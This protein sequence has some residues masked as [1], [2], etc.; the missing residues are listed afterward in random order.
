MHGDNGTS[1]QT[2]QL[3]A[4]LFT[5][6]CDS[7]ILVEKIGDT[8]AAELFKEHDRLVLA[9]QQQWNGRLID[10]SDGLFLLFERPV[11]AL[12]FAL[13]YQRGLSS[14]TRSS[15]LRL[16]ARAGLH[17]GEVILWKN[18]ADAV[19]Y[20][21]KPVE[22][23]GLA[24]PVAARLMQLARPGQILISATAETMVRRSIDS[25]DEL[26]HG[27]K[28]TSFGLWRFK[29]IESPM[30][31]FGAAGPGMKAGRCPRPT[32]KASRVLPFWRRP[33][34][35][36]AESALVLTGIAVLWFIT[37]SEPAIAFAERDW[38]VVADVRNMTGQQVL[39][40]GISQA[41]RISLEQSRYVN[42][43]GDLKTRE[44]LRKML[45]PEDEPIDQQLAVQ[46]A[47][48]DG[49]RA[50][51]LPTIRETSGGVRVSVDVVDPAIG[52]TVYTVAADG[53]GL[54][55]VLAST[56][57][58]VNQ[59]RTR[60]GEAMGEV[61]KA[62]APLPD[63]ATAD[64][65][66][67]HAYARAQT[68]YGEARVPESLRL[69]DIAIGLDPGFAMAR[70]GKVRS[71]AALGRRD[72]ARAE[73]DR[74]L[75]LRDRLTTR[76]ALYFDAWRKEMLSS[77]ET[78]ALDAWKTLADLYPDHHG[79]NV[80]FAA[81]EYQLG[82]Y[83]AAE[84]AASR[85]NVSQNGM[86]GATLQ[87]LGRIRLARQDVPSALAALQQSV[88]FTQGLPSRHLGAAL[89][90]SGDRKAA[91]R[92][93]ATLPSDGPAA[94]LEGTA[95][96]LDK[97]EPEA[98]AAAA[99]RAAA[100]C[101]KSTSV[102][103]FLAVVDLTV[104]AAAGEC[105]SPARFD[106]VASPLLA[107]AADPQ[108]SDR[109]QRLYFAASALYAGQRSGMQALSGRQSR[110]MLAV[111]RDVGDPRATQLVKLLLANEQRIAGDALGA[112]AQL[113]GMVD[114]SELF[115]VHSALATAYQSAGDQAAA[116]RETAWM[117]SNRGR[118]YA[119]YAGSA[120]LQ[121]LNVRDSVSDQ[122]TTR[123]RG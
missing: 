106:K 68:A 1:S 22:V 45:L 10:R 100:G 15:N 92:V 117:R 94:W 64:L 36:A 48:R 38:V 95:L 103:E 61:Q 60:L 41:F 107:L 40:E 24:K 12:G 70:M 72:D 13:S 102:C 82:H 112:A 4:L 91:A 122:F 109:G 33:M 17:V 11:D 49:A 18:G 99:R 21:A 5:D 46:I 16:E 44:T 50:V 93:L 56:D 27:L 9:L 19:A 37:R 14:L 42:V 76:E 53:K 35:L 78:A 84:Q 54:S 105:R 51:L 62:S 89:A 6:L 74:V 57:Q 96:A 26:G 47:K 28:W 81:A 120:V 116:D 66:A 30:E 75:K 23:E 87:L 88:S 65:D 115:Q 39:D 55:S 104:G 113:R 97:G 52:Q 34:A 63:V 2:P 80:N 123:C 121:S 118:A 111:A 31:V 108:A 8:A 20:G 73:L 71:M 79:A 119:E 43:L 85:A 25:L 58:V 3:R 69:Y 90:A 67:L 77:S 7:L 83:E 59:L 29:G 98:A 32:L 86:R 101:N 110:Q 114:G